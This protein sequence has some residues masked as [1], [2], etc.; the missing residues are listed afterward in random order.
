MLGRND[1]NADTG[2]L[3]ASGV[4]RDS[5]SVLPPTIHA[6]RRAESQYPVH[7][8]THVHDRPELQSFQS[9]ARPS[10]RYGTITE[11]AYV[12][13]GNRP[14]SDRPDGPTLEEFGQEY[15]L[16]RKRMVE[17]FDQD[18]PP[19]KRLRGVFGGSSQPYAI[20]PNFPFDQDPLIVSRNEDLTVREDV[21]PMAFGPDIAT[22]SASEPHLQDLR[23]DPGATV[24]SAIVESDNEP[25]EAD[26]EVD[27][28]ELDIEQSDDEFD[29]DMVEG[30]LEGDDDEEMHEPEDILDACGTAAIFACFYIFAASV[31]TECVTT[32][33]IL[34]TTTVAAFSTTVSASSTAAA[35]FSPAVA[36][37]TAAAAAA[38]AATSATSSASFVSSET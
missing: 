11:P 8:P 26:D 25:P 17:S 1:P 27:A 10:A 22:A 21:I 28:V 9:R 14:L 18:A 13:S 31:S 7:V 6:K 15:G 4:D 34:S 23:S 12:P 29:A 35:A 20:F 16:L 3:S 36:T 30:M 2:N 19:E 32:T 33:S 37:T 24:L 38:A 5:D